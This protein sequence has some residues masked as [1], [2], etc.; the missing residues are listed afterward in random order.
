MLLDNGRP[1][2]TREQPGQKDAGLHLRTCDRQLVPDRLERRP[3][4]DNEWC[5]AVL[6]LH[7]S[8]HLGE[9]LGDPPE[10]TP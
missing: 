4:F 1:A 2:S 3:T 6:R 10:G 8:A 7:P 9:R 5:M